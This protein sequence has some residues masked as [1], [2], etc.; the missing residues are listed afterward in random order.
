MRGRRLAVCNEA[1]VIDAARASAQRIWSHFPDYDW[2]GRSVDQAFPPA[3]KPWE[4][5]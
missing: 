4:S 1:E 3:I 2:A 5:P